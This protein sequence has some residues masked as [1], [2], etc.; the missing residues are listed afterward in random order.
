MNSSREAIISL[1]KDAD[2]A[3]RANASQAL[4]RLDAMEKLSSL[5]GRFAELSQRELI[6]IMHSL[7]GIRDE[8]CLKLGI[9]AL[10]HID[11]AVRISALAL[12][13]DFSDWRTTQHIQDKLVDPSPL[14]RAKAVAVLGRFGNRQAGGAAAKLLNDSNAE[15]AANAAETVGLLGFAEA[16]ENLIALTKHQDPDV[17]CAAV[18]ALGRIGQIP[19]KKV[20]KQL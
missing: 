11:E 7:T 15:V 2:D 20:K 6:G 9:S 18:S 13:A 5:R 14:V 1:L 4:D 3:V 17:R 8:G 10:S 16:A 12:L 19:S